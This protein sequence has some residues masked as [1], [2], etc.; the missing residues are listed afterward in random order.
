MPR[1]KIAPDPNVPLL[2]RA[3][4]QSIRVDPAEFR[5]RLW[6]DT[7][8]GPRRLS[9]I[10]DP[11][12]REDFEQLDPAIC[13][14]TGVDPPAR[15]KD[16]EPKLFAYLERPRGH[17]KTTDQAALVCNLLFAI[18]RKAKGLVAA[19]DAEQAGLLKEKVDGFLMMRENAWL[20]PFVEVQ[21]TK[22]INPW[23]GSE[24]VIMSSDAPTSYG[25]TPDF[26]VCDELTHWL[27]GA[28]TKRGKDEVDAPQALWNSLFSSW[29]K[30]RG[31]LLVVIAN[32][33]TGRG[34][35]WQW[36][37]REMARTSPEMYFHRL[38]GPVASWQSPNKLA[39]QRRGL[40]ERA[41]ARLWLNQW[42]VE[43]GDAVDEADVRACVTMPGPHLAA[44]PN[45]LYFGAIDI[46]V[47]RDHSASVVFGVNLVTRRPCVAQ[48]RSWAPDT[49]TGKVDLIDVQRQ[50]LEDAATYG[51]TCWF[52]DP[53]QCEKSAQEMTLTGLDM[54]EVWFRGKNCDIM[55]TAFIEAFRDRT[56]DLYDHKDLI[57]DI[58]KISLVPRS[59][60]FKLEA[61]RDQMGH[62][63]RGITM[64]MGLPFASELSAS[65][66]LLPTEGIGTIDT[67]S[68]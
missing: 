36:E 38:E 16:V 32:A 11:W 4:L 3:E 18:S 41:Y 19:G 63:D 48:V 13:G 61:S 45:F 35:C 5:S 58:L 15:L 12:Q 14:M 68:V 22:I 47:R 59:Y 21:A 54:R 7:D 53:T 34:K 51:A 26:I 44:D 52:F 30:R 28:R 50:V 6:L 10:L 64:A 31:S 29:A 39:L 67:L 9:E 8:T 60:G 27:R 23:T 1:K 42:Q 62:A 20:R 43:S 25:E 40:S 49:A 17:S 37:V 57:D 65:P 55:A 33:G 46:G 24:C 56:V 2:P 66:W